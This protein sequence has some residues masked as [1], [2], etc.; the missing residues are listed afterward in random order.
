[1]NNLLT[2]VDIKATIISNMQDNNN[3][4]NNSNSTI[5]SKNCGIE[6]LTFDDV[7][8]LPG[9]TDFWRETADTGM[10]LATNINL[11][12]PVLSSP[13]DTVT[14]SEMAIAMAKSG[15]IGIIHRSMSIVDQVENLLTV[16]NYKDFDVQKSA[17]DSKGRLLCG[18]AVGASPDFEDRIKALVEA[19][20]DVF[21]LDTAQG[22]AQYI[23]DYIKVIKSL[24]DIPVIGGNVVTYD[25]AMAIMEVGAEMIRVG[26]GPGS[27]CTTRIVT[28]VGV[29]QLTAVSEVKRAVIDFE[30][31]TG[32]KIKVI[33]DGGI[34]QI[35]DIAKAIAFGAD[36]VMLGSLLAGFDQCPGET[37]TL[38]N[39]K[40]KMYRG[41]GSIGAM[42]K[43]GAA[44]YGQTGASEK[45]LVAEGVEGMVKHKGDV[46]DFLFQIQGGL[47][48][49]LYNIGGKDI[50]E[51]QSKVK[52]IKITTATY[53]ES[54]P[55]SINVISGGSSFLGRVG[56]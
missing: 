55:H 33:A 34:K 32:K 45:K 4:I 17:V 46:S 14:E 41:M 28:G 24:T 15:G 52:Y 16:K 54:M 26:M 8:L 37:I 47:K 10:S 29:P 18:C 5:I 3:P 49:A 43:G 27:I 11:R 1:V 7:L 2:I 19:E 40:Y 22:F 31:R 25:G 50:T 12:I 9:F 51:F 56:D 23:L 13:M 21:V 35:G 53:R 42:Q 30:S 6:G 44:R 48:S 39:N 20:V 38:D 36:A